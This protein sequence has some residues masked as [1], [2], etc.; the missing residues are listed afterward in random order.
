MERDAQHEQNRNPMEVVKHFL[1]HI[2][3]FKY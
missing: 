1:I 3:V 2:L